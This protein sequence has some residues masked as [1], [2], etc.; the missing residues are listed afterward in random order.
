LTP[1]RGIAVFPSPM[2]LIEHGSLLLWYFPVLS[3]RDSTNL[4]GGVPHPRDG[5]YFDDFAISELEWGIGAENACQ[6]LNEARAA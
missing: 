3:R 6:P 1:Q 5:I 2:A 4:G